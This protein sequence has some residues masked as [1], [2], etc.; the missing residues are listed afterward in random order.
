MIKKQKN[1]Y[2][3]V[4]SPELHHHFGRNN[5]INLDVLIFNVKHHSPTMVDNGDLA[6]GCI[7]L[8]TAKRL[9]W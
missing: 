8:A 3:V 2:K 1:I 6:L 4:L 5:A 7:A 9:F